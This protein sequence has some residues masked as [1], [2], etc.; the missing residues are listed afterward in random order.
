ML[1]PLLFIL[2]INDLP[3]YVKNNF[4]IRPVRTCHVNQR[5]KYDI[6]LL[7]LIWIFVAVTRSLKHLLV[8]LASLI[9][10]AIYVKSYRPI[11][12]IMKFL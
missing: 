3:Q 12:S 7:G 8:I 11:Y 9:L 6:C 5:T 10:D 1:S 4:P 2:Y